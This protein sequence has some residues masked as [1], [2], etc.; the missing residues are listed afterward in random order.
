MA[1]SFGYSYDARVL[2]HDTGAVLVILP[3]GTPLDLAPHPSNARITEGIDR[4]LRA[5]GLATR[6]VPI[7]AQ[8]A[9]AQD[10]AL[11]HTPDYIEHVAALSAQ[12][13]GDAGDVA[14]LG[15]HSYAAASLSAGGA[16]AAVDALLSGIVDGAYVLA[17][18][19]G[20]HALPDRGMGYC[21]F[22]N[23]AVA[24]RHAQRRGVGRV[25]ILDWDVHH[26]NGTQTM[27]YDDPSVLFISLHQEEWYP[28]RSGTLAEQGAGPG[29]GFTIN[30]PLPAGT[31]DRGY[32][33]AMETIVAPAARRF[34]PELIALSAGQD[35]AMLD[36][37]G[38]ML[39][40]AAGFAGLG[41]AV[42]SLADDLCGGRV[43]ALQEGGYSQIYAPV[44]TLLLLEGLTGYA[45]GVRDPYLASTE[46]AQAETVYSAETRAALEAARQAHRAHLGL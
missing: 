46:H 45:T 33:E 15:P 30:V 31:G 26:G 3:D 7:A 13:G 20:H 2:L 5:A 17:R 29:R 41:R 42:R 27:F 39:V 43:L 12:G 44:C 22:N 16:L 36:P 40:S 11:A 25:L 32:L 34:R 1:R 4:L 38:R 14:P 24:V 37:L 23:V 8:P 35:P 18:P 6:L 28:R 10:L 9:S 21:L 19:P